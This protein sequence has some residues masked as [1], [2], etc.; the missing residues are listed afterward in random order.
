[1][2]RGGIARL[3]LLVVL[4]LGAVGW[5]VADALRDPF[6][7]GR[8]HPYGHNGPNACLYG[9]LAI[10]GELLLIL[11]MIRPWKRTGLRL[12]AASALVPLV[13][14]MLVSLLACMHAGGIFFIHAVWL[15]AAI[16]YALILLVVG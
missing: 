15:L 4:A 10:I 5:S 9:I 12:R 14:H 13:P 3:V 8:E 2:D 1:M 6:V 16:V 11:L 7:A